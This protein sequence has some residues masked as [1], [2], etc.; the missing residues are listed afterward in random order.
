MACCGKILAAGFNLHDQLGSGTQGTLDHFTQI[1]SMEIQ[2]ARVIQ[3]ALWSATIINTGKHLV[4][5]GISGTNPDRIC[6]DA[7]LDTRGRPKQGSFFGDVGGVRGFLEEASGE[8]YILQDDGKG[9]AA[10]EKHLCNSNGP[11]S[12]LDGKITHLAIAGN[13]RTCIATSGREPGIYVFS[14]LDCLLEGS[15]PLE[16]Y[17]THETIESLVASSTTF[18]TLGQRRLRVET[19]GDARYQSLLGRTPSAQSPASV[20]AVLSALDGIPI[21][22]IAAGKWLVAAVSCEKDLYVWGH[23]LQLPF[24][25]D[26]SCFAKILS[27]LDEDD[28]P[29]DVHLVDV[30]G[31]LDVEEVAVGDDHLIVRT[32]IGDVWGYGSNEF[33]QLGLGRGVKST[34]GEW[35]KIYVPAKDERVR[36]LTAGPLTTLLV[37]GDS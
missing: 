21:A 36:E 34:Q 1:H 5:H 23:V 22:N 6:F 16:C 31:N 29:E 12:H 4:H 3:C 18:T 28:K 33:G 8:L 25:V 26:H 13:M 24:A 35:V 30:G 2:A 9:D 7:L 19:F 37:V 11:L 27:T 10:F 20:P 32:T 15:E 14:D 17:H